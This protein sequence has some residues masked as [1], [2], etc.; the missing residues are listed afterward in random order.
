MSSVPALPSFLASPLPASP[1]SPVKRR[2]KP[3]PKKGTKYRPRKGKDAQPESSPDP[4]GIEPALPS[5][6]SNQTSSIEPTSSSAAPVDQLQPTASTP[7][8]GEGVKTQAGRNNLDNSSPIGQI[9]QSSEVTAGEGGLGTS[10]DVLWQP[11]ANGGDGGDEAGHCQAHSGG[12]PKIQVGV[13]CGY[14]RNKH[15]V[16]VEVGEGKVAKVATAGMRLVMNERV[17]VRLVWVSGDG[18]D[19][20]YE[21]VRRFEQPAEEQPKV[22][23]PIGFGGQA[24]PRPDREVIEPVADSDLVSGPESELVPDV[25]DYVEEGVVLH[26]EVEDY[27]EKARRQAYEWASKGQ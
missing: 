8:G 27:L 13:V 20:E 16:S 11:S 17:G 21:V 10:T 5:P 24:V 3:G 12:W 26:K 22:A 7:I 18:R 14:G 2:A 25:V 6:P 4:Q 9:L 1:R 19:A 23:T 15:Y